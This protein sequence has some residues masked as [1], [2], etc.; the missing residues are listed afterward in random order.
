MTKKATPRKKGR[1]WSIELTVV[2]LQFRW[3]KTGRETLARATPF[4]VDLEREPEHTHDENAIKVVI[5]SDFKLKK[6]AGSHLGYLRRQAAEHMAPR[7]DNGTLEVVK[8]WV[9]E[10]DADKGEA[11]VAARFRDIEKKRRKRKAA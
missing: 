1:T 9:N 2:G 5:A 11:T 7:L 10:I 4:K 8:M 3:K 6:L